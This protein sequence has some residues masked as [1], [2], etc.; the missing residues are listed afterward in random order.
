MIHTNTVPAQDA[1]FLSWY[2]SYAADIYRYVILRIGVK[3]VAEDI[4]SEIFLSA[5]KHR[6]QY[7]SGKASAKTWL[8][9]IAK[10]ALIDHYRK[11][12]PQSE[13]SENIKD[14]TDLVETTHWN[15]LSDEIQVAL[16]TLTKEQREI[17]ELRVWH[18]FSHAEIAQLISKDERAVR[19]MFH[20]SLQSLKKHISPQS[21]LSFLFFPFL[22]S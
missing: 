20:R 21:Y 19:V 22:F 7:N 10:N 4:V 5:W 14:G 9:T 6:V 17:V 2:D 18:G 15:L 13:L 8:F 12:K 11:T 3:E 1:L 16:Q